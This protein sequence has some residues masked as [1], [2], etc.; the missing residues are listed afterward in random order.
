MAVPTLTESRY[1]LPETTFHRW[2]SFCKRPTTVSVS[3]PFASMATMTNSSPPT[4]ASMYVRR[5]RTRGHDLGHSGQG[6]VP[7]L[8]TI[9]IVHVLQFVQVKIHE[10]ELAVA[11]GAQFHLL[12]HPLSKTAPVVQTRELVEH[13]KLAQPLL[14]PLVL[15]DVAERHYVAV[16]VLKLR[17]YSVH[18]DHGDCTVLAHDVDL[19]ALTRD[20]GDGEGCSNQ[21]SGTSPQDRV[22]RAIRRLH[23][24]SG[25]EYEDP[26][27][28]RLQYGV[29]P[30]VTRLPAGHLRA[31]FRG[32][33]F[34]AFFQLLVEVAQFIARDDEVGVLTHRV[35]VGRQEEFEHPTRVTVGR[36]LPAVEEDGEPAIA[37]GGLAQDVVGPSTV[38][39]R[40]EGPIVVRFA[41][42][43][44]GAALHSLQDLGRIRQSGEQDHRDVSEP[45]LVGPQSPAKTV[46]VESGHITTSVTTRSG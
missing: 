4:R 46:S 33:L 30:G 16:I 41:H 19:G 31:Q 1:G 36:V 39:T 22:R 2:I 18:L 14:L 12:L 11:P 23:D 44:V 17:P 37:G 21:V 15:R 6:P 27:G 40:Q 5:P 38:D 13:R 9:Q 45:A 34:D 26:V 29:E 20:D 3:S 42:E 35:I 7:L 32:P 43:S 25:I 28:V 24:P 10:H 8:V